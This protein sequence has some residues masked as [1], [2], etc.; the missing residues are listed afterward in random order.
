MKCNLNKVH[1]KLKL[2]VMVFERHNKARGNVFFKL[3]VLYSVSYQVDLL[4]SK[5]T[6]YGTNKVKSKLQYIFLH[7][8][9]D[10]LDQCPMSINSDQIISDQCHDFD[11][12][13]ALIGGVLTIR[14]LKTLVLWS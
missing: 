13:W 1:I 3:L 11:R 4:Q 9:Q 14:S 2:L 6:P 8:I 12:H 5:T 10:S 7:T